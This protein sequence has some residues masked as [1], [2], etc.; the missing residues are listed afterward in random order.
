MGLGVGPGFITKLA[1]KWTKQIGKCMRKYGTGKGLEIS[2][3][4]IKVGK[5]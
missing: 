4:K 3:S 2:Q 5:A 1:N